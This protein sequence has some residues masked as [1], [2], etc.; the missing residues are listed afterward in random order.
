MRPTIALVLTPLVL[1]SCANEMVP[2]DIGNDGGNAVAA[3]EDAQG[4]RVESFEWGAGARNQVVDYVFVLDNSVSMKAVVEK[5]RK[6]FASLSESDFPPETRIAVLSTLPADPDDLARLHDAVPARMLQND[7]GF[8]R[9]VSGTS[10]RKARHDKTLKRSYP[11]EGC[12]DDGWFRPGDT[13]AQGVSC[14]VAHTQTTLK[15]AATE[16]GLTAFKQLLQRND[17]KPTFRPGAAVNVVFV[18]D[19]HDPGV[20]A[21]VAGDLLYDRPTAEELLTLVE[22]DNIVSSI[23]F[24]AIAPE[25]ECVERWMHLGPAYF[26]AAE[27]TGGSMVDMCTAE[28]YRP[29]LDTVFDEGARPTKPVFALGTEAGTVDS[30]TVDG[31]DTHFTVHPNG[32][33]VI[34][35][36]PELPRGSRFTPTSAPEPVQNV[37][38]QFTRRTPVTKD[39]A[40]LTSPSSRTSTVGKPL[41]GVTSQGVGNGR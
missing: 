4:R 6:G 17:G 2:V 14:L 19:T 1:A 26:D 35:D 7:A 9:F 15:G 29:I 36:M 16:A 31:V 18:S 37:E 34:V 33:I 21:R 23:R 39:K 27:Y 5:V 38:V 32:R 20:G 40:R 8:G 25:L 22:K 11:L 30:V 28:D 10:I 24:H 13:N 12:G 41:P 3:W